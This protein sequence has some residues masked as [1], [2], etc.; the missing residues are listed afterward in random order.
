MVMT[1][2]STRAPREIRAL[3]AVRLM[4]RWRSDD[5]ML[6]RLAADARCPIPDARCPKLARRAADQLYYWAIRT[7][8]CV[9][10]AGL[11]DGC[12]LAT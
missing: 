1:R 5:I 2:H 6:S 11:Q 10:I 7:T 3:H 12:R 4:V 9:L 8:S